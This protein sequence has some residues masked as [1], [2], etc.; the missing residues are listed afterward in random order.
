MAA[1]NKRITGDERKNMAKSL[2]RRYEGGAS[3]RELSAKTKR[4]YGWVNKLLKEAGTTLRPRG[5][6]NR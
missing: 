2:R 1:P 6:P 5:G 3:V 4:S